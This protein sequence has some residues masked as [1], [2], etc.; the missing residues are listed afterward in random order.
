MTQE[1][2]PLTWSAHRA[3]RAE[4]KAHIRA[5]EQSY[6]SALKR[7]LN[8]EGGLD[9]LDA[10]RADRITARALLKPHQAVRPLIRSSTDEESTTWNYHPS[11]LIPRKKIIRRINDLELSLFSAHTP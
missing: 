10:R 5:V 4:L 6:A 9:E 3:R 8:G 11:L 1:K 2:P 7:Y